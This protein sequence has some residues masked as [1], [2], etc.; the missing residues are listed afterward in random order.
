MKIL[1]I[2][3]FLVLAG[4]ASN[5]VAQPL[6]FLPQAALQPPEIGEVWLTAAFNGK[7]VVESDCV[8]VRAP[9]SRRSTTVLWYQGMELHRDKEG[10]YLRSAHTGNIARFN[11][12]V[13]FGGGS[14]SAEHIQNTYPE[15]ARR[16]GPPYAYG[17]P[18]SG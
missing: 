1:A 2:G 12:P 3:S 18:A 7:L 15:V 14:A 6:P 4:C 8:K 16:C 9:K 10:L 5:Q 17:Y 13:E 11:V